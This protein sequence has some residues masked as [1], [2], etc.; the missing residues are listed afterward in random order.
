MNGALI[1]TNTFGSVKGIGFQL[2][3]LYIATYINNNS[4]SR[5]TYYDMQ[6]HPDYD[7]LAEYI[8]SNK[9]QVL[10]ISCNSHERFETYR[11][12]AFVKKKWPSI[13]VVVGGPHHTIVREF[14]ADNNIDFFVFNDGEIAMREIVEKLESGDDD[15]SDIQD[16]AYL[17]DGEYV[18]NPL[19]EVNRNIDDIS[20]IDWSLIDDADKYSLVLPIEGKPEVIPILTSRGCPFR[21]SFCAAREINYKTIRWMSHKLVV[22]EIEKILRQ[23]PGKMIFVYDDHFLLKKK[24]VFKIAEE[25][26]S[27]NLSFSWGCYGRLD[28]V[29]DE[30]L[31]CVKQIGCKMISFGF[32]SGSNRV[33][34]LMNKRI[35]VAQQI[36]KLRLV[37]KHGIIPRC[38]FFMNYPG[39]T[40]YNW[41]QTLIT[42]TRAGIRRRELVFGTGVIIYP[43]TFV[44]EEM[45]KRY[46]PTDFSWL[47]EYPKLRNYK[48]VPVYKTAHIVV[49]TKLKY[50]LLYAFRCAKLI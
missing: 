8:N 50:L 26:K 5:F 3:L 11:L 30:V 22:D 17:R 41:L 12:A 40:V 32:E 10:G 34:K 31:E 27:R 24:R 21:C 18:V 42:L 36:D 16:I 20:I 14:P 4:N 13:K 29:D 2:G 39:E 19:Q 1:K 23:F 46:L 7:D 37:R 33:L 49:Q 15:F 45:R 35:T 43:G 9:I 38:S 25:V 28:S 44:F 47:T 6:L 48:D